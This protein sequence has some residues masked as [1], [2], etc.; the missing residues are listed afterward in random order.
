MRAFATWIGSS[1]VTLIFVVS[2]VE[3]PAFAN[4]ADCTAELLNTVCSC[5]LAKLQPWQGAV[6]LKEVEH[7]EDGISKREDKERDKLKD[8]PIKVIAG[9]GGQL[10]ITD[11]HHGALAWWAMRAKTKSGANGLC[12]VQA[13][14]DEDG[15]PRSF[16]TEGDFWA[17][18]KA[19]RLI[20]LNDEN[21]RPLA[22]PQK[23]PTLEGLAQ[24]DDPYRSL[25]WKVRDKGFCRPEGSK[26]FLEFLWADFF[27]GHQRSCRSRTSAS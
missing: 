1:A 4:E 19:A 14:R 23:L 24:H 17:A 5:D 6:G 7:K 21:G 9:P 8:D 3:P 12:E 25:A 26:E 16:K 15:R 20:R 11:H 13:L 27:R 10:Y 2:P 22:D 18:L